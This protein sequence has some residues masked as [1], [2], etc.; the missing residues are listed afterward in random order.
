[1]SAL[2]SFRH[3]F[4]LG[5]GLVVAGVLGLGLFAAAPAN[6][7]N[8][9]LTGHDTDFH[10]DLFPSA[11]NTAAMTAD[12]AFVRAGAPTPTLPVLVF[13][14]PTSSGHGPELVNAL[15]TLLGASHVVAVDVTN[16]AQVTAA[17][18]GLNTSTYSAVAVASMV[19][20]GG[21]DM[22][23]TDL[24][25]LAG[26]VSAFG[27]FLTAGGG[28]LGFAGADDPNAY[29]YVPNAAGSPSGSP[30]ST[31]FVETA[32][33]MMAGLSAENGDAT[34]N[35]FAGFDPS[36]TVA[37]INTLDTSPGAHDTTLIFSGGEICTPTTCTLVPTPLPAA[38][39]LFGTGLF[40]L[41]WSRRRKFSA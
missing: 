27:A 26:H 35:Y 16:A 14:D 6:A 13:D 29:N 1:M 34:H 41:G 17:F 11:S 25:V 15:T 33:G 24:A 18:A 19:D 36:Y 22:T 40:L 3:R 10:F 4:G 9:L 23:T 38:L 39:P 31:G 20:C 21:C 2:S 5:K 12:V 32:A 8:I 37:E 28:I 7:G 30:P